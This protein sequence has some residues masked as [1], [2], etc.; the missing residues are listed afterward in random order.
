MSKRKKKNRKK[1]GE[2]VSVSKSGYSPPILNLEM[3]EFERDGKKWQILVSSCATLKYIYHKSNLEQI[4]W[5]EEI[6]YRESIKKDTN[7]LLMF[8][9]DIDFDKIKDYLLPVN[10]KKIR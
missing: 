10:E 3:L 7:S 5:E 8:L 4:S 6:K 1:N 9:N 2:A